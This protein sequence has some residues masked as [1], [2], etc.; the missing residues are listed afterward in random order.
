VFLALANLLAQDSISRQMASAARQRLAAAGPGTSL[1]R[2]QLA[3][4]RQRIS[5]MRTHKEEPWI[6]SPAPAWAWND[7]FQTFQPPPCPSLNWQQAR[8]RFEEEEKH[9]ALPA[10]LLEAVAVQESG[11]YPCAVSS[12]GATGLM[13]LMP[14]TAASLGVANPLD[15]WQNL[16]G[17][18]QFLRQLLDRYGGDLRL[19]LGAYNA[20]P[21]NVDYFGG[22][23]PFA[24]TQNY[25]ES[26]MQRLKREAAAKSPPS[27]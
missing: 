9:N 5:V 16:Q 6:L 14:A 18:S 15:P 4:A 7:V 3:A 1:A 2:Q 24:E 26:V 13:Q 10:G 12:A 21:A 11:L 25:V 20:G 27:P 17:G 22:V 19:A 23:P 8:D